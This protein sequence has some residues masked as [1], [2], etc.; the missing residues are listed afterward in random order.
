MPTSGDGT[1][2]KNPTI[3]RQWNP[4]V[5]QSLHKCVYDV[6]CI[7]IVQSLHKCVYDV[8]NFVL[9]KHNTFFMGKLGDSV[10]EV[11]LFVGSFPANNEPLAVCICYCVCST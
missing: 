8:C 6:I 9:Y 3:W 4:S 11:G 10:R 5:G 1:L 7:V 2:R